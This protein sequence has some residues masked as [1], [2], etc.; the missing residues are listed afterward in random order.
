MTD[1]RSL[2]PEHATNSRLQVRWL[3]EMVGVYRTR[4]RVVHVR[5]DD[6]R[7]WLN[8]QVSNDVRALA[9]D[10]AQYATALTV[11]GRVVSD[12]WVVDEA[13]GMAFVL[14]APRVDT[15]LARFEQ[16]IIMEDVELEAD[17]DL[18][19]VTVQGPRAEQLVATLPDGLRHY[20]CPRL[21]TTGFDVWVPSEQAADLVAR[22][23][24]HARELGGGAVD[25]TGWAEAHVALGVPRI[26]L[27]FGDDTYPQEAGLGTRALSFS[28]GCYLGQEV[29]YMLHNRGQLARRLVQ[30]Q[31]DP[32][33]ALEP[34]ATVVDAE[35]K[36][37]GE[38]TSTDTPKGDQPRLGLAFVKR[39]FSEPESTVW[40]GGSP[41]RVTR[42]VGT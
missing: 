29:V 10:V 40:V 24:A 11:K 35:G 33:A 4:D 22:L 2:A 31:A 3:A 26:A 12:L 37:L 5:G 20:A 14:P 6:A 21:A 9:S 39:A 25:E 18:V 34:G 27:D 32:G 1:P 7:S 16:Y 28:K 38:V 30:L 23:S 19:V 41:C 42:V 13:P 15:A 36:R 8:G 17:P